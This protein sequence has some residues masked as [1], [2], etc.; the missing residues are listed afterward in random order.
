M[1]F[2]PVTT[3]LAS[4][5]LDRQCDAPA[6]TEHVDRRILTNLEL[7]DRYGELVKAVDGAVTDLDHDI[8]LLDPSA[9][10]GTAG[11]HLGHSRP[12]RSAVIQRLRRQA[13]RRVRDLAITDQ[14]LD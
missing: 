13:Q 3:L 6:V 2:A 4:V 5:G 9:L 8:V 1:A 14:S 7:T 10:G 11:V 12:A